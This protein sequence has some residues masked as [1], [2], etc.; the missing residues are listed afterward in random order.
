VEEYLTTK[1]WLDD[2]IIKNLLRNQFPDIGELHCTLTVAARKCDTL[3]GGAIQIM[4]IRSNHWVC[5][6]VKEDMSSVYLYDS[7]YSTI[8]SLSQFKFYHTPY[9]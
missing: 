5:I 7:K 9:Q 2:V 4:H 3:H 6:K 8:P 1:L